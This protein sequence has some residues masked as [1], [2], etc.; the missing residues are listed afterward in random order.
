MLLMEKGSLCS[1]WWWWWFGLSRSDSA[2][3]SDFPG[4]EAARLPRFREAAS[5]AAA[6]AAAVFLARVLQDQ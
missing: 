3:T 5:L 4:G 1:P 2:L 6:S